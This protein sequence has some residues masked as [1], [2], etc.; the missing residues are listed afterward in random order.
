MFRFFFK[1]IYFLQK[2]SLEVAYQLYYH[3]S[4][5]FLNQQGKTWG[6]VY[7]V[8]DADKIAAALDYLNVR[9]QKIGGYE[10]YIVP[11]YPLS[12]DSLKGENGVNGGGNGSIG[13]ENGVEHHEE[14]MYSILYIATP[15]CRG[16]VGDKPYNIL[17]NSIATACGKIGHNIEY[18]FRLTDFMREKVPEELDEHLYTLDSLVR[19]QIGLNEDG[20]ETWEQLLAENDAF[21]KLVFPH[22]NDYKKLWREAIR[23]QVRRKSTIDRWALLLLQIH[24]MKRRRSVALEKIDFG[25]SLDLPDEET[26]GAD[27][28]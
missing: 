12:E 20:E 14:T 5:R 8:S 28:N 7:E 19:K 18:L 1:I 10:V 16:F 23:R 22:K 9:E 25:T 4:E 13:K 15:E 24:N 21:K 6:L 2:I 11:V 3:L 27:D 26:N 17:A